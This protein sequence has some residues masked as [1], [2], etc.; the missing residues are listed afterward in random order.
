M[1][2]P[3]KSPVV[4][5]HHDNDC[6]PFRWVRFRALLLCMVVYFTPKTWW[7][8]ANLNVIN[9][10]CSF[11]A[12]VSQKSAIYLW[13]F[14]TCLFPF[15]RS[16]MYP[17]NSCISCNSKLSPPLLLADDVR[18]DAYYQWGRRAWRWRWR[19]SSGLWLPTAVW[20]GGPLWV[21]DGVHAG[22]TRSSSGH[23]ERDSGE[24]G[25]DPGQTAWSQPWKRLAAETT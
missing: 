25:L 2:H 7:N 1:R 15:V 6:I 11:P 4:I 17:H 18:S 16:F 8:L 19:W 10:T 14:T 24:S 21:T 3:S 5:C 13:Q 12:S 9:S 20:L 22:G 23:S